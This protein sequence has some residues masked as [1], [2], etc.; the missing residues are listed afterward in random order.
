M[1]DDD[2]MDLPPR[3]F[4]EQLP[5]NVREEIY[6]K[7]VIEED[8]IDLLAFDESMP[9]MDARSNN[10]SIEDP[11]VKLQVE[12]RLNQLGYRLSPTDPSTVGDGNCFIYG[13]KD[14]LR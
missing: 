4:S 6:D 10:L 2:F 7:D 14:Q 3:A 1:N 13:I 9:V 8:D 5:I 12:F 11:G